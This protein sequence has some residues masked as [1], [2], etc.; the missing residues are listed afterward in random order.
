MQF[1]QWSLGTWVKSVAFITEVRS[2]YWCKYED[3]NHM[4][5]SHQI[6]VILGRY[7]SQGS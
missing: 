5:L 2:C 4:A 7:S 3:E 6:V 1:I